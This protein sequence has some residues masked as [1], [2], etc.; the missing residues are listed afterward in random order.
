LISQ[1]FSHR[2]RSAPKRHSDIA[3]ED[4]FRAAINQFESLTQRANAS[5][6]S[7]SVAGEDKAILM[8]LPFQ[9]ISSIALTTFQLCSAFKI[10]LAAFSST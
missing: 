2:F 3:Q 6:D 10:S 5:L 8:V 9:L 1:D 7:L 4:R